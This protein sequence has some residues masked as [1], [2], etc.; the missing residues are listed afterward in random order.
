[1]TFLTVSRCK[2]MHLPLI[3]GSQMSHL[4]LN[5]RRKASLKSVLT[6]IAKLNQ[7]ETICLD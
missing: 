7:S 1:M 2:V 5:I 4:T 3:P 6:Y